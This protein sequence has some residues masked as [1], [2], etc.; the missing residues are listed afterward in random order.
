VAPFPLFVIISLLYWGILKIGQSTESFTHIL[1]SRIGVVILIVSFLI[2]IILMVFVLYKERRKYKENKFFGLEPIWLDM[3]TFKKYVVT[4]FDKLN[5]NVPSFVFGLYSERSAKNGFKTKEVFFH[6]LA[7]DRTLI[8][9]ATKNKGGESLLG[10]K[11]LS[12]L[13]V[14]SILI[15][16]VSGSYKTANIIKPTIL[17]NLCSPVKASLVVSD[18]KGELYRETVETAIENHY[19]IYRFNTIDVKHSDV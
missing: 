4:S 19:K 17:G 3:N 2:V 11:L 15:V 10:T 5:T 13:A 1:F 8:P 6:V 12:N 14:G 7:M 18:P 16:G 9:G